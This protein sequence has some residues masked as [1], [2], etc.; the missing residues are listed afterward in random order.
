MFKGIP[1]DKA[2]DAF[3][4]TAEMVSN[5]SSSRDIMKEVFDSVEEMLAH[6]KYKEVE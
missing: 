3:F 6:D 1:D 2:F 4:N 5:M